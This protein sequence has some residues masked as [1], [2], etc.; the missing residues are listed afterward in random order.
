M[1]LMFVVCDFTVAQHHWC[2]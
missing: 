1:Q 2:L